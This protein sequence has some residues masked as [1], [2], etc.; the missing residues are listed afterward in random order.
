[1]SNHIHL[2]AV[3][4]R[5]DSLA[6]ALRDAHTEH[7]MRFSTITRRF[8][9]VWQGRFYSCPPDESHLWSAVRYV[10]P[11]PVRAR[12]F[13][14]VPKTVSSLRSGATILLRSFTIL[15]LCGNCPYRMV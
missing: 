12:A 8:G 1:M 11:N 4:Q 10:E 5:A 15:R 7:A 9:H 2:V 3:P 6:Q 14:P 13:C